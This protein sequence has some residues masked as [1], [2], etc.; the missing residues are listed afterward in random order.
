MK[1]IWIVEIEWVDGW[2]RVGTFNTRKAAR[3]EARGW[4]QKVRVV[5]YIREA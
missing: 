4:P 2:S 1:V 3:E 5:K